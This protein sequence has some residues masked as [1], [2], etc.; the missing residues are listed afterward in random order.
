MIAPQNAASIAVATKCGY[1]QYGRGTY[2]GYDDLL[3]R[4]TVA[5]AL[6]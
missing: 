6:Y 4:R 2:K 1:V 3:F 5:P